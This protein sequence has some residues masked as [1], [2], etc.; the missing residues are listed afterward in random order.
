MS[1]KK[2]RALK[3]KKKKMSKRGGKGKRKKKSPSNLK[4]REK[5]RE[6]LRRL[7]LLEGGV[8][9]GENEKF[10]KSF[11]RKRNAK[12]GASI[13][14]PRRR[15]NPKEIETIAGREKR[16]IKRNTTTKKQ[17]WSVAFFKNR[18]ARPSIPKK[19]MLGQPKKKTER[20]IRWGNHRDHFTSKV[21]Q[22]FM[23]CREKK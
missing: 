6:D 7:A 9:K 12:K 17:G 13:H 19:E 14:S 11:F 21:S 23:A 16:E 15:T 5:G 1:W 8:G 3:K 2:G 10:S 22:K 18:R 4:I 20:F